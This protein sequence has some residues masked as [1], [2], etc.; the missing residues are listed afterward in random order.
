MLGACSCSPESGETRSADSGTSGSVET[1]ARVGREQALRNFHQESRVR[2]H[3]VRSRASAASS[4][5]DYGMESGAP[6]I[7]KGPS[8]IHE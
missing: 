8:S 7:D 5:R 2:I 1:G 3:I 6:G 4:R